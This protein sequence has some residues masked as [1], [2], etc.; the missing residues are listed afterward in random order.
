MSTEKDIENLTTHADWGAGD[1]RV[2][3]TGEDT[4]RTI[5]LT[6][7]VT[8]IGSGADADIRLKGLDPIAAEIIHDEGDEFVY[9]PHAAGQTSARLEP[10]QSVDGALGEVL[11]MGARFTLG[12]WSFVYMREE[13]ADHG[14]PHGGIE[15]GE[16]SSGIQSPQE[17]RPDY[18]GDAADDVRG[19]HT[20]RSAPA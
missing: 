6:A 7:A 12:S 3:L 5:R 9:V 18:S 2:I 8:R 15:G 13:F 10:I 11:R 16:G 1:P 4:R 20:D 14:R 19:S 17:P